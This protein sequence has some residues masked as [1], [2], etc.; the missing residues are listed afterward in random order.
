MGHL[1]KETTKKEKKMAATVKIW[2]PWWSYST[3]TL[4]THPVLSVVVYSDIPLFKHN[5]I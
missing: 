3:T 5:N 1:H 2:P 4:F